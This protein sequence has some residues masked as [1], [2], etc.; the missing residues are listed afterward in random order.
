M[1]PFT[2]FRNEALRRY[3]AHWLLYVIVA[4][5][6][7]NQAGMM[8]QLHALMMYMPGA[9]GANTTIK[10]ISPSMPRKG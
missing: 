7:S 4:K 5:I 1:L 10:L 3:S 9:S 8:P 6:N 2:K